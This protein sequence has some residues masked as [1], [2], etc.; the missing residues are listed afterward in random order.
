MTT[1]SS[2]LPFHAQSNPDREY[3]LQSHFRRLARHAWAAQMDPGLFERQK[4]MHRSYVEGLDSLA[5]E[6][7]LGQDH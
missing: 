2:H 6:P 5:V 4:C 3:M 7:E 1:F